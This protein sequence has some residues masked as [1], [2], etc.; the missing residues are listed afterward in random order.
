[1]GVAMATRSLRVL[2]VDDERF[3]RESLRDLLTETGIA[4]EV[5]ATG[6]EALKAAEHPSVGVVLLD[7]R[8]PGVT[9]AE[10]LDEL[11]R[12]QPSLRVIALADATDQ[13]L[14][15]EAL[16]AG[17]CD[18]LAKPL[19]NEEVT[20]AVR[21][22]LASYELESGFQS[23]SARLHL[24]GTQLETLRDLADMEADLA[25]PVAEALAEVLGAARTS[26]LLADASESVL[27]VGAAVGAELEPRDMDPAMVAES[28]AGL[29]VDEGRALLIDDVG[30]DDR[31]RDRVR[32]PDY[33][34]A[35]VALA[36]VYGDA[37]LLGV[38]CATDRVGGGPFDAADLSLV[39]ILALAL[40]RWLQGSEPPRED[41]ALLEADLCAE[42]A[43]EICEA[44]TAEIEPAQVLAGALR[45][46]QRLLGARVASIH[47][48]DGQ[49][50]ELLLEAER[51]AGETGDRQR[52]P[53]DRGLTGLT[54]QTG[55]LVATPDPV[56]DS[57][58][59]PEVDTP[60]DGAP[61][62][63]IAAPLRMRGKVLGVVR[64]FASPGS[65]TSA[66]VAEVLTSVLSAAIR[67]VLLY[68]S[69]L[70]SIDDLARAR[71]EGT[72]ITR[73]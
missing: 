48:I 26:L 71:A 66:R 4:C 15:L 60:A 19:H 12:R 1:M 7:V 41:P 64:V 58:F 22:A 35:S 52:L 61:G 25:L 56:S 55:Q 51:D 54:L 50:G 73:S 9:G 13:T 28:M 8:L 21:R 49:T 37:G 20:L 62:P 18:Y 57:R 40:G 63:F 47:L 2:V 69:L 29:A 72:D 36:P 44:L 67:N 34:T 33:R 3:Y 45:P 32:R 43:R 17:A 30:E 68:R 16:R 53:R 70:E 31:C 10:V 39:R 46:V 24:L 59:D 6:E 23:Q 65:D 27:R 38:L 14:V 5:V 42:L 11:L